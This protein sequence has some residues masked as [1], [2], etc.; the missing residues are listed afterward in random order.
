[1]STPG[2]GP[3]PDTP[4]NGQYKLIRELRLRE[5]FP[6]AQCGKDF[7]D[8]VETELFIILK[9]ANDRRMANRRT[10]FFSCDI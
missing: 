5:M 8:A 2:M 6:D 3:H 10:R 1:M 9:R 7:I 4:K